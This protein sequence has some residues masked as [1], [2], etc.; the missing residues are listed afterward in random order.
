[1]ADFIDT[2]GRGTGQSPPNRFERLSVEEDAGAWEEIA[3]NDPDFEKKRPRTETYRDD[4]QSI[5]TTNRSP[6]IGFEKS[7]NPYR[8]CEHGCSYCYARPYHEY[9]GFNAGLDFET[10]LMVKERAPELLEREMARKSW[11]PTCLACSGVTDCYQP[12]EKKYE[13]TRQC[14]EVLRDFRNPV[15][16]ITKNSLITRDLDLLAELANFN[17]SAVMLSITSL[18][19]KLAGILEPRASRPQARLNAVKAISEAGIPAG[20]S[21]AP[22]I[23]GLNEHE[24]PA[25]LEAAA[26]HGAQFASYTILRLPY[27]VKD[28][29]E[30]WLERHFPGRKETVLG[31]IRDLRGG[32]LNNSQY[33]SRMSGEGPQAKQISNLFRV[34]AER[35]GLNREYSRRNLSIDSFR[36][37]MPGQMELF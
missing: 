22:V 26:D 25:L 32:K 4:T 21:L 18:D 37:R 31:R 34:S 29:F 28:I 9:L 16:I 8:G 13:I 10:K 6:D 35:C 3:A 15:G 27:G 20:V 5:I 1:M 23:P 17:A 7:L 30:D 36:R 11:V 19:P 12:I 2:R 24:I 33:G 14:L